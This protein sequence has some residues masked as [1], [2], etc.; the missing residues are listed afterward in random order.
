MGVLRKLAIDLLYGQVI[1]LLG[2]YPKKVKSAFEK[3]TYKLI[4][5]VEQSHNSE[6]MEATQVP[7]KKGM[8]EETLIYLLKGRLLSHKKRGFLSFISK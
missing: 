2:I 7:I 1:S 5:V 4:F 6:N 8:D 3:V